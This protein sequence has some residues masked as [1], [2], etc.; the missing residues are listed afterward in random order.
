MI[1]CDYYRSKPDLTWEIGRQL[2][3]KHGVVRLPEDKDFDPA[4]RQHWLLVYE[5]FMSY[6]IK[7]IIIEPMP[8]CLHDHIKAGDEK[9]DEC[10]EKVL[11]MFPVMDELD[12][13]TI[14]FNWMTYVGW[15][16]TRN[17]IPERGGALVTGF[18]SDEYIPSSYGIT[19]EQLWENYTYF[20]KV[21]IPE[22]EKY[23]IFLALHP[24]DPPL[25]KLGNVSR[26]MISY[27]KIRHAVRDIVNSPNLGVTFCQATY[28]LM[29]E[30]LFKI[31]PELADKILFIHFRNVIGD[32]YRFQET[33]HDNGS[34]NMPELMKCYFNCGLNVP[35]RVDHVPIMVG[36]TMSN[37]GYEAY[38]RL[39]AIGYLRG[40]LEAEEKL[41][42]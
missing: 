32:K 8:N 35:I 14:C 31:I 41:K 12:I 13:R 19:E 36:D 25:S 7:P 26:I 20:L 17:N 37:P 18:S 6:G 9:R 29:G 28:Y 16:R 39:Y 4:N 38:G 22:A 21:V 42:S 5:R 15:T 11:K 34:L 3:I 2:G 30:D 10:I 40:I 1:L 33:F 24:D 27:D 23:G